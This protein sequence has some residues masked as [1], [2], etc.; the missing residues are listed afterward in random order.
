M[1]HVSPAVLEVDASQNKSASTQDTPAGDIAPRGEHLPLAVEA[2]CNA[3]GKRATPNDGSPTI[4]NV[5]R[6]KP[7]P[8][9]GHANRSDAVTPDVLAAGGV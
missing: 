9:A 6:D 7:A 2:I 1:P 3:S 4:F 8:R 5:A